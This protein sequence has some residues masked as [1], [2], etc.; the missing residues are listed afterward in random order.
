MG[1]DGRDDEVRPGGVRLELDAYRDLADM[2]PDGIVV[3]GPQHTVALANGRAD[4]LTGIPVSGH[5]GDDVRDVLALIDADGDNWWQRH[6]PWGG[7]RTVSGTPEARVGTSAGRTLLL[8][9]RHVRRSDRSLRFLVMSMRDTRARDR[10]EAEM[11]ALISTAA[12]EL[13]SPLSSVRGFS[14]TLQRRWSALRDDQKQWMLGAIESDAERLS[15]LV[16]E[17]LD[18]SRLDTGRLVLAKQ[19]VDVSVLVADRVDRMIRR[20][21]APQRFDIVRDSPD[22]EVWADGDRLAQVV[23]NLL[24]NAVRHGEG[25]IVARLHDDTSSELLHLDISDEGPGI[26]PDARSLV[27]SRFWQGDVRRKT[28]TGLGLYVVRGLV[29]AHGGTVEVLDD[30]GGATLRVSLPSGL[31]EHLR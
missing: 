10:I 28:G 1:K 20:G 14:R 29:E 18:I 11:S 4:Q 25:R 27:F 13:R 21:Q 7:L 30:G 9:T 12:H 16:A 31:P 22:T 3:V 2:L 19:A 5:V 8:T 26:P 24:E 23:D 15:R 17:L 6:D